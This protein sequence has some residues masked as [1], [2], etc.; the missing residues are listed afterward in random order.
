[1]TMT[2]KKVLVA[3]DGS[4]EAEWALKKA[5]EVCKR[6]DASLIIGHVI[7]TRNYP[8]MEAYDMTISQRAEEYA[9]EIL[10]KYKAE[11][12]AAGIKEVVTEIE[13][14]SP[15]VKITRAIGPKHEAD[16]IICG[17]TG[18]NAVERFLIGSVSENIVRSAKCD[19]LIVR[20]EK[21]ETK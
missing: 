7:D 21:E 5:I 17:A 14:G 19:V 15:K 20:T 6:N 13:P 9:N 16:L 12:E 18:L 1:M 11:A 4:R 2:Y 3:V 8:T 10:D